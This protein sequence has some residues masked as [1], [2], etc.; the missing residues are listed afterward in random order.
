MKII[1]PRIVRERVGTA[2]TY[3]GVDRIY[4]ADDRPNV[5]N[6]TEGKAQP[7]Y[8]PRLQYQ[9]VLDYDFKIATRAANAGRLLLF[10]VSLLAVTPAAVIYAVGDFIGAGL[11]RFVD[12][13][14]EL[15]HRAGIRTYGIRRTITSL[16]R[17]ITNP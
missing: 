4:F 1:L 13:L 8:E 17:G 11:R 10:T 9:T 5:Y 6:V 7:I 3:P 12:A 2:Y 14:V 15:Y 16:I